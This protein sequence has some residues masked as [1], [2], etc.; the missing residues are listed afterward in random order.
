MKKEISKDLRKRIVY[1]YEEG[2]SYTEIGKLFGCHRTTA[3]RIIVAYLDEERVVSK[4][5]GFKPHL[6][7]LQH[8]D[9]IRSYISGNCSITLEC[10]QEKLFEEFEVHVSVST[11]FRAIHGLSF[12]LKRTSRIPVRRDGVERRRSYAIKFISFLSQKDGENIFFFDEVGFSMR[13]TRG[14]SLKG[15]RAVQLVPNLRTRNISI[16]CAISKRC[17]FFF[18]QETTQGL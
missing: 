17:A 13:S 12:S 15:E 5:R 7:S 10:I 4:F 8:K 11:I 3:K 1:A 2:K 16:C 18:F 9:A 6:L 14:R